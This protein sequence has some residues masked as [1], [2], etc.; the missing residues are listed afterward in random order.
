MIT[1]TLSINLEELAQQV[2][3]HRIVKAYGKSAIL[4]SFTLSEIL[5]RLD[6]DSVLEAIGEE[7]II[8]FLAMEM[9]KKVTA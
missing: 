6:H 5:E 2:P 4:G 8:D 7:K 1:A 3:L 9:V